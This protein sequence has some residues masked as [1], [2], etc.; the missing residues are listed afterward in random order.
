MD[1]QSDRNTKIQTD[2]QIGFL[3]SEMAGKTHFR[4]LIVY[5]QIA[6]IW[7]CPVV[8]RF[9]PMRSI[10]AHWGC[11]Y[12]CVPVDKRGKLQ[13]TAKCTTLASRWPPVYSC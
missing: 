12:V 7:R 6:A 11:S 1:R 9:T 2:T 3:L 5:P 4:H 8:F 10:V 13:I